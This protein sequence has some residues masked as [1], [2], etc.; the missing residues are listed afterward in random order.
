[1]TE[2]ASLVHAAVKAGN[3]KPESIQ[4][5]CLLQN[6]K[7]GDE[8]VKDFIAG[9]ADALA[10]HVKAKTVEYDNDTRQYL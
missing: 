5:Y 7:L 1:M 10:E 8:K 2:Y 3:R 9:I 4:T 6:P